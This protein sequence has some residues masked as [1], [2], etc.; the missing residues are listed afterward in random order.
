MD[1]EEIEFKTLSIHQTIE[2]LKKNGFM[3]CSAG[4]ARRLVAKIE[5]LEH[6]IEGL[7]QDA[8]GESI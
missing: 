6:E 2:K 1:G 5:E 4:D 8:A 7:Y 3:Y